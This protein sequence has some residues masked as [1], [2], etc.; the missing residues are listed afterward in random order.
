MSDQPLFTVIIPTHN[1][2]H[3]LSAAI[4]SALAQELDGVEILVIDDA[5][6][7]DTPDVVARYGARVIYRR[8]DENVGPASAWAVG[9]GQARGQ[10]VAK[11]DADDWYLPGHLKAISQAF[12]SNPQAG[13]V[14]TPVCIYHHDAQRTQTSSIRAPSGFNSAVVFRKRLLRRFFFHMP[15]VALRRNALVGHDGPRPS[16]WMAHDWEYLI[17]TMSGWGCVV[18]DTP[19]AVYRVHGTSVTRSNDRSVRRKEDLMQ[20]FELAED[21]TEPLVSQQERPTFALGLAETYLRITP[22]R[23]S[24]PPIFGPVKDVIFAWSLAKRGGAPIRFIQVLA[25]VSALKALSSVG[26]RGRQ[27]RPIEELLPPTMGIPQTGE[28]DD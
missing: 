28:P 5:S 15:G 4:E 11:L 22:I 21:S 12:K 2:G 16:L 24:I 8:L 23:E 27:G 25:R 20:L 18:L 14:I 7:D 9:L 6:T 10:Y 3:Y 19:T 26:Y 13:M 17:R 1:Y